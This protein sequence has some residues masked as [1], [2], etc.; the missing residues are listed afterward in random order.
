MSLQRI[1]LLTRRL[2]Q[3]TELQR[4]TVMILTVHSIEQANSHSFC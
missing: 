4:I 3:Y 1:D 2:A